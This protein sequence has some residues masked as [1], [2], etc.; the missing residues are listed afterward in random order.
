MDNLIIVKIYSKIDSSYTRNTYFLLLLSIHRVL[1]IP[2][3]MYQGKELTNDN[4]D[5]K[6]GKRD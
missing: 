1:L 2:T 6:D 3:V 5:D 4:D